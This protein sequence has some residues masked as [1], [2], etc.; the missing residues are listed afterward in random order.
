[1]RTAAQAQPASAEAHQ[2]LADAYEKTGNASE[3]AKERDRARALAR[4]QP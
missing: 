3:A 1:L 4:K 2:F